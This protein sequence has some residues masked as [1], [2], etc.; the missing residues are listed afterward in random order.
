MSDTTQSVTFRSAPA[1][2][3]APTSPA[4]PAQ[5][6]GDPTP[7]FR[8]GTKRDD[9]PVPP[10]LYQELEK[11]PYAVKFLDLELYHSDDSFKDVKEQAAKL[12]EYVLKQL[13]AQ[14]LKD[15]PGS[16][17]EVIDAMYK[18]IGKSTNEDP[19]KA[20]K[21]LSVAASALDRLNEAKLQPILSAKT[22]SP[23]EFEDV[24]P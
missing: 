3:T 15:D 1:A 21:R 2:P 16:Y 20:L 6:K 4:A 14:G 7:S 5:S 23:T 10:S 24:Q 12:D 19:T 11:K 8:A 17:K 18:Q 9:T 22:L 13:K